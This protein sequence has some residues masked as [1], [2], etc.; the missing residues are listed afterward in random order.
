MRRL[1]LIIFV[2]SVFS[3]CNSE[4]GKSEKVVK[5]P[6]V[7]AEEKSIPEIPESVVFCG[8][9]LE[10]N[11]FESVERLHREFIINTYY[12]SSTLQVLLKTKRYFPIIERILKENNVPDDMKYL[13]VAESALS[14][15]V[16]PA[17]AKGFWQFMPT[18]GEEFGL[19][20]D[21]EVDERYDIEKS[22]KA[23]CEYL[24]QAHRNFGDWSLAAAS[25]NMGM[26]GVSN[27]MDEQEVSSYSDLYLNT[28]T[29]RYVMRIVAL[30]YIIESPEKYGFELSDSDYYTPV[31]TKYVNVSNDVADLMQWAKQNGT[32]YKMLKTL[33]P[34]LVGKS[35]TVKN[36]VYQI[37]LPD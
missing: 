37:K 1:S 20:I 24:K 23:A 9:K 15:A 4:S 25:Y 34:W 32:N 35:L 7:Q 3:S 30:K 12:H 16:S 13:C 33:N 21:K 2:L 10:L 14:N 19:R 18:T 27:A 11:D 31:K 8:E 22:T 28:E 29:S 17:G 5:I 26:G 36:N 6:A